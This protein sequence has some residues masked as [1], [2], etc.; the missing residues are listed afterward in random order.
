MPTHDDA[1]L[2]VAKPG[3]VYYI[4]RAVLRPLFS[5][6][7]RV[8]RTGHTTIPSTGPVLLA[9]NHLS[10][11]D[12]VFIPVCSTRPVQ[13]LTKS[14][15]FTKPGA[16]GKVLKWFFTSIGA[17]AVLRTA[18]RDA[19]AALESGSRILRAGSVFAVFPEGTR[20]RDGK[21]YRGKSGAAFMA[22]D[23]GAQVV[24]VGLVG[25]GTLKTFGWLRGRPRPEVRFGEPLDFSDLVNKPKGVAR[26]E[27]TERIMEAIAALSEQ[28]RVDAVNDSSTD[29]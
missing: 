12:T 22:L 11:W 21:L 15:F 9:S 23:T 3:A 10:G 19:Q 17:V 1:Q 24:P 2:P 8:K 26:R 16:K 13:F 18:G 27:A 29:H 7:Y 14:A 6:L 5:L 25:T 20:S 28:E 4:G